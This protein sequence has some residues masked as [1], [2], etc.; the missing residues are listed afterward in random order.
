M[1]GIF[2]RIYF[3]TLSR[4]III[5]TG[6]GEKEVFVLI[7][8]LIDK[9]DTGLTHFRPKV[10]VF[11]PVRPGTGR[12]YNLDLWI[13]LTDRLHKG[14]EHWR[15]PFSPLFITD[16]KVFEVNGVLYELV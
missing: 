5:A 7:E 4:E 6:S 8:M 13:E 3:G 9:I 1:T 16:G 10:I 14:F 2:T 11:F 12:T 15:I